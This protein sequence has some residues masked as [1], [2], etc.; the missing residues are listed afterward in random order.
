MCH[1]INLIR[2]DLNITL[3]DNDGKD[4]TKS[5]LVEIFLK[6]SDK[7]LQSLGM[8]REGMMKTVN[9]DCCLLNILFREEYFGQLLSKE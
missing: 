2:C 6:N 8:K 7:V 5:Y 3:V 4:V 1:L 9:D